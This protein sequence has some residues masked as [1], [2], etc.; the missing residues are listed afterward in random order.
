LAAAGNS[1]TL[2]A[3]T[4]SFLTADETKLDGIAAGAEVNVNADWNAVSGDAQIL[5]KPTISGSNTGDVSLTGTP[6]YITLSGQTITRGLIDLATDVTGDLPFANLTQLSAHQVLARAGSGTGDVA[7]VTMGNDTILGRAGSGDVDDLSATQVRSILNVANG[8]TAN[9]SDATLLDRANHTGTQT[10]STISDFNS[11]SRA[12]TEAEL[13]AGANITITP[14][15]SGATRQL[16]IASSGGGGVTSLNTLTG[17]VGVY[18][19]DASGGGGNTSLFSQ[20]TIAGSD[21]SIEI[22]GIVSSD[23]SVTITDNGNVV[24]LTTTGGGGG[25]ISEELAIAY[26]IA[27]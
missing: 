15:G 19:V 22:K 12:Q 18:G 21:L 20:N 6:D 14:S 26:A 4:A 11:A 7:G 8:A 9:S 2:A 10:S 24:D 3:T 17:D 23:N 13:V 5:N 25:G 1:A 16:T 27:L